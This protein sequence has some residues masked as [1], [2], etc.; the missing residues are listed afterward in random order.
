MTDQPR[1]VPL[2]LRPRFDAKPWGGDR[3]AALGLPVPDEAPIGEAVATAHDASVAGGP[4]DGRTLGELVAADPEGVIGARGVAATGGAPLFPLL[5]KLIDAREALSVQ[6]HPGDEAAAKHGKLGKTEAWH[7]LSVEPGAVLYLGLRPGTDAAAF[8]AACAAADGRAV[9][10]LRRIP[11]V[12][13]ETVVIPAGTVHALGAGVV[14]YELQQPSDLTYRLD[15]WGRRD[16]TGR[17]RDLH[18]DDGL[19]VSDA[20]LRPEPIPPITLRSG[21]GRRQLLAAC[22]YFALERLALAAGERVSC[23]ADGS[24]QALTCLQGGATVTAGGGV[25]RVARGGTVVVPARANPGDVQ[26]TSPAVLLRAWVPDLATEVVAPAAASGAHD[27]AIAA[28]GSP[29]PDVRQAALASA[30]EQRRR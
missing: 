21:A 19:A 25:V 2:L 8:A 9:G 3:L 24:A 11:A 27:A 12:P 15:D 5:V 26:A 18:L 20:A 14:V 17:G 1:H 22:R 28:L 7:V 4:Y 29:L 23:A 30:R 16:A 6:V 13:G 10:D